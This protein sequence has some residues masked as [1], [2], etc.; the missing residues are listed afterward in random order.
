MPLI[1]TSSICFAQQVSINATVDK[2]TVAL[3]DVV[4]YTITV[5]GQGI[6]NVSPS[7]PSFS[8]L[9]VISRSQSSNISIING[10]VSTAYSYIYILEP[11]K[12]GVANIGISSITIGRN[13]YRCEPISITVTR[14]SGKPKQQKQSKTTGSLWDDIDNFFGEEED[15]TFWRPPVFENEINPVLAKTSLSRYTCY[16]NQMVILTFTFYRRVN[17]IETPSYTPPSTTG[18]WSIELPLKKGER[19]E[20]VNGKQY[21]AQDLK[22]ALFPTQAGELTI[23]PATVILKLSP[24]SAP[25]TITTKPLKLKVLPLPEYE[26][27]KNLTPSVGR[28]TMSTT[29]DKTVVERGKPFTLWIKFQGEGNINTI[30]EPL[31]QLDANF[32]RLTVHTT[33]NISKGFDSVVGSKTFEYIIMPVK[34]GKGRVGP[35]KFLYFDPFVGKY[36]EQISNPIKIKILPSNIPLPEEIQKSAK[37][38]ERPIIKIDKWII[39]KIL[40]VLVIF[41]VI[42]IVGFLMIYAIKKYR[43]YLYSNP[44]KNRQRTAM[45][46][47]R[48]RLKKAKELLKNGNLKESVARVYEAVID[49]LGDKYNFASAGITHDQLKDILSQQGIT[50]DVRQE[51]DKF[52]LECDLIRFTPSSLNKEK[53]DEIIK[54]A[55]ELIMRGLRV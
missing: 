16:V 12:E 41:I 24:I 21:L 30:S 36:I 5:S 23:P 39:I 34:E 37:L 55:E 40:K 35:V 15:R 38:P 45:K 20:T 43:K 33:D 22:T 46:K 54:I 48:N 10:R 27:Y 44:V 3:D 13:T 28:W 2:N 4:Q 1:L 14:A 7:T 49:Y 9:R 18:F 26:K 29:V 31:V 17:L 32:K 52:I 19:Y 6:N 50:P 8:N 53:V 11:E 47:A 25:I 42:G 51:I